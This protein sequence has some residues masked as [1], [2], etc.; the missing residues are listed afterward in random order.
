MP[1]YHIRNGLCYKTTPATPPSFSRSDKKLSSTP[2][3]TITNLLP[4]QRPKAT[5][6]P[7]STLSVSSR[8]AKLNDKLWKVR[9]APFKHPYFHYS[10]DK[11]T[12]STTA[13][14]TQLP[15]ITQLSKN[16]QTYLLN[17]TNHDDNTATISHGTED[18]HFVII[19]DG[20]SSA[21]LFFKRQHWLLIASSCLGVIGK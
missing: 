12:Q 15:D 21:A 13:T 4:S 10:K 9:N 3:Y 16:N 1:G 8:S 18:H 11:Q 17:V 2:S 20:W 19:V 7:V 6:T 14:S 5:P